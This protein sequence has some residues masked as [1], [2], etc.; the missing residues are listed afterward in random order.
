MPDNRQGYASIGV[1]VKIGTSTIANV[2]DF[3]DIGG[4]PSEL[5]ATCLKDAMKKT[6][7]GVQDAKAW[8]M[9]YLFGNE[10]ATSDYRVI[11]G[12]QTAGNAVDVEVT[13]PDGTKFASTGYVSTY[14]TGSKVDEL[15]TAKAIIY[16]QSD[17]TVT[18]PAAQ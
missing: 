12:L 10:S 4:T 1:S 5:D 16:L 18:N 9:T 8:E 2:T 17:W 14:V 6:V 11:K 3:S 13:F 7:P 15:L